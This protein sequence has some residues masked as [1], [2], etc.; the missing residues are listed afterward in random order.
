M[1][2]FRGPKGREESL[3]KRSNRK[4]PRPEEVVAKLRQADEALA[5]GTPIA[6]SAGGLDHAVYH[7]H[8]SYLQ[9]AATSGIP[10][11][12]FL[13]GSVATAGAGRVVVVVPLLL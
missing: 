6:A 8:N 2:D 11:L 1:R 7:A 13:L 4:R 9:V 10:T 12:L 3:M 5:K